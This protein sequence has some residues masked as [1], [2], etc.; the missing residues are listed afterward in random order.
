MYKLGQWLS[1]SVCRILKKLEMDHHTTSYMTLG[2]KLNFILKNLHGLNSLWLEQRLSHLVWSLNSIKLASIL[3]CRSH[4][5]RWYNGIYFNI[6]LLNF[7][8][9]WYFWLIYDIKHLWILSIHNHVGSVVTTKNLYEERHNV[10][11]IYRDN[12][13]ILKYI[14][15]KWKGGG[16][17]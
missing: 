8:Y 12:T 15:T 13:V 3:I 6:R 7:R 5:T 2:Y 14:K 1:K 17:M 10:L 9:E 11:N 16:F 4:K